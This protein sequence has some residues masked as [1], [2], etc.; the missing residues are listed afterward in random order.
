MRGRKRRKRCK[1]G[2]ALI[3][4]NPPASLRGGRLTRRGKTSPTVTD[5]GAAAPPT[6]MRPMANICFTVSTCLASICTDSV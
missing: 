3:I 2:R 1:V 5:D 4:D 6:I